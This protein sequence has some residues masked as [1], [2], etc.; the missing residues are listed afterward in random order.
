[1]LQCGDRLVLLFETFFDDVAIKSI[2]VR[3]E[4]T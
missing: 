1:M 2:A 3:G 4:Q